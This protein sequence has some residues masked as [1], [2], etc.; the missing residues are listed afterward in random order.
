MKETELLEN[1]EDLILELSDTGS[2]IEKVQILRAY[3]E[4]KDLLK[5]TYD[6]MINFYITR[7][8]VPYTEGKTSSYDL[9][10]L[11]TDLS[12]RNITGDQ[13][14]YSVSHYIAENWEVSDT[15]LGIIDKDLKCGINVKTINEAFPGLIAEFNVPLAKEYD[16]EKHKINSKHFLSRKLDG[17]RC[18]V[19]IRANNKK[20]AGLDIR[21][22]SRNGKEFLTLDTLRRSIETHWNGPTDIILDGEVCLVDENMNEDFS[23][24]MQEIRRKDHTIENPFLFVFDTYP[25]EYFGRSY[26]DISYGE[27]GSKEGPE[28]LKNL[29]R[30]AWLP[31][32]TV[33][34]EE[35]LDLI[36][37]S[38]P[39]HWEGFIL[40]KNV[41]TE[42]KRS[43]NLLKIKSFRESDYRIINVTL[44]SMMMNGREESCISALEIEHKGELVR[45][46]SGLSWEQR[47]AWYKNPEE[48]IGKTVTVKYFSESQDKHGNLS[49][50]F[51]ILKRI[52]LDEAD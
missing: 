2:K 16:P 22:Y 25:I 47:V 46:G 50:R 27:Y 45:V 6:P 17:V 42:F 7:E 18:L 20:N 51:P 36:V 9:V 52:L 43:Q 15:I 10:G 23:S 38:K 26:S 39:A 13:A 29:H 32:V 11:L 5:W 8:N 28:F 19:F 3:P 35:E 34:S 40:R 12:E 37:S 31:Q 41:P 14:R 44:G 24:I 21:F 4:L 33:T 1:M 48:I 30:I 49:L